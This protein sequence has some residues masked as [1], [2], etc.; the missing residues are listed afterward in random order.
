MS[1]IPETCRRYIHHRYHHPAWLLLSARRAPLILSCLKPLFEEGDGE[2]PMEEATQKLGEMFAEYVN[3]PE[4]KITQKDV[5]RLSRKELREWIAK[6]LVVERQ[7]MILST[8]ALQKAMS[9]TDGLED[10][11]MTSTASRLSTAQREIA[12]LEARLN[13]DKASRAEFLKGRIAELQDELEKVE[14]GEFVVLS[15]DKASENIQEVYQLSMSL[16]ADFRRVEDSYRMA[17]RELRQQIVKSN[18]SRSEVLDGMLDSHDALLKTPEGQVFD[19]FYAQLTRHVELDEMK[20]QLNS[21]LSNEAALLALTR[22]Q[23]AELKWLISGLVRESNRVI[24][25]RARGER[26]V[27]SYV[28][29]GLA[30]EHHRVGALLNELL[31]VAID[32]DW[33]SAHIRRQPSVLPPIAVSLSSVPAVQRLMFKEVDESPEDTI[34]LSE[35]RVNLDDLGEDFWA[36]FDG[37][38]RQG[39]FVA[40]KELLKTSDRSWSI[41]E[42][43]TALPPTHDLETLAYWLTMAR[44]AGAIVGDDRERVVLPQE[45][46]SLDK[47]MPSEEVAKWTEFNVPQI[48]MNYEDLEK[49]N[50]ENLG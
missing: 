9:F 47:R 21:I 4:F 11:S 50:P 13:P 46:G 23:R 12:S 30:S 40:T 31:E 20:R 42:L 18:Q 16:K 14:R 41:G 10:K 17:D 25:A 6:G 48:A 2:V 1:V 49:M 27:K 24:Q 29:T 38:D 7:G 15:G 39:L 33:S 34:D 28:K 5:F 19:G 36:S 44:E 37:L 8:D 22:K 43:A 26:D 32:V 35:N 45:E 3:D